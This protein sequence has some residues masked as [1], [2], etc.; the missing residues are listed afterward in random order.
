MRPTQ[1]AVGYWEVD[2]RAKLLATKTRQKL[3]VYLEEPLPQIV[4]GPDA[5]YLIDGHHVTLALKKASSATT[6]TAKIAANLRDRPLARN[7][8]A[9]LG[10]PV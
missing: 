2:R 10:L 7:G 8:T 9:P 3:A 6:V 4:V 5:P 1:F